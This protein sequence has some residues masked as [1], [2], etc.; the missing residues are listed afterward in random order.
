MAAD[1]AETGAVSAVDAAVVA[2]TTVVDLAVVEVEGTAE[3]G[4]VAAAVAA[5][6]PETG[7]A[8]TKAVAMS[9]LPGGTP[10]TS[11]QD[12]SL[13]VA[14]AVEVSAV[15]EAVAA[16]VLAATDV[17]V[18]VVL[19]ATVAV[20]VAAVMEAIVTGASA[21]IVATAEDRCAAAGAGTETAG[22]DVTVPTSVRDLLSHS[23]MVVK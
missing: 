4:A 20:E 3:T 1:V 18:A 2:G 11:A 14:A 15:A 22:E 7:R 21:V 9:T 13:V 23:F 6:D 8:M 19:V 17:E 10:A 16:A 12:K 5:R